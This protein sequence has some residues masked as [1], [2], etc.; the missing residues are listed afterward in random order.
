VKILQVTHPIKAFIHSN[1]YSVLLYIDWLIEYMN[2]YDI[3]IVPGNFKP[4]TYNVRNMHML[5][6]WYILW[7]GL[8]IWTHWL[9]LRWLKTVSIWL[10]HEICRACNKQAIFT[11]VHCTNRK[12]IALYCQQQM[13]ALW[14]YAMKFTNLTLQSELFSHAWHY[15]IGFTVRRSLPDYL[16]I[17]YH[18]L[19]GL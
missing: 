11:K 7:S 9:Q 15:G 2:N 5:F 4:Y 8:V 17:I 3:H 19:P 14:L 13:G 6:A 12:S 10:Q 16:C 18:F 1:T